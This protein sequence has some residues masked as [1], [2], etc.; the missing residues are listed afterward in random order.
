MKVPSNLSEFVSSLHHQ[1][2]ALRQV[3]SLAAE[4]YEERPAQQL[5]DGQ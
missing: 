1:F 2:C 5:R 4:P 3:Q